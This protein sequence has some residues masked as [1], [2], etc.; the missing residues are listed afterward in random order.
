MMNLFEQNNSG[1]IPADDYVELEIVG[2]NVIFKYANP[3]YFWNT[4]DS[5]G[6]GEIDFV[7]IPS[8]NGEPIENYYEQERVS[9]V[10]FQ[11]S[12]NLVMSDEDLKN[13]YISRY[14][15]E[16]QIENITHNIFKKHLK[17][18][19]SEVYLE[20]CCLSYDSNFDGEIS[21]VYYAIELLIYK[22]DYTEEEMNKLIDEYHIIINTFNFIK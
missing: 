15:V 11:T 13:E 5:F 20:S 8:L 4:E 10:F 12:D 19:T 22:N 9:G 14:G 2:A 1:I 17:G 6:A 16:L 7:L 21:S 3:T 18:E